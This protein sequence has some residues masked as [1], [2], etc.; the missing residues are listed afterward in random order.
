[1]QLQQHIGALHTKLLA[2]LPQLITSV[3]IFFLF[4]LAAII[5]KYFIVRMADHSKSRKYL[6]RLLGQLTKIVIILMGLIS[7]LGTLG[8]NVMALVTSLGLAGFAL[9][10]ALKDSLSNAIAG[11]MILFYHPFR[12]NDHIALKD[13]EGTVVE[14]NLRYTTMHFEDKLHMVPNATLL[15]NIVTVDEFQKS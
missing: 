9:G 6:L 10:F 3:V 7:S 13:I 11:F 15:S 5:I 4:W 14:I 1:M 12:I 8:I 2:Y